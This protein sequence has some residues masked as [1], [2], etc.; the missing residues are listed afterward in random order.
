MLSQCSEGWCPPAIC[1]E[2]APR[3][4]L[5]NPPHSNGSQEFCKIT[6]PFNNVVWGDE[7]TIVDC[8]ASFFYSQFS[9]PYQVPSVVTSGLKVGWSHL[10][11]AHVEVLSK[12]SISRPGT[13]WG[14][15]R[16]KKQLDWDHSKISTCRPSVPPW[17][18]FT[19]PHQLEERVGGGTEN[20]KLKESRWWPIK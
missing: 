14:M 16:V 18:H 1:K 8:S 4:I 2:V 13:N 7:V 6:F 19:F 20:W 17:P 12:S 9:V 3:I 5:S 11:P 15:Q 10:F